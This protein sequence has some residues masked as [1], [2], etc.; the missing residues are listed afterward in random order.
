[1]YGE[2]GKYQDAPEMR[3]WAPTLLNAAENTRLLNAFG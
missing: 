3:A 1:M 2:A